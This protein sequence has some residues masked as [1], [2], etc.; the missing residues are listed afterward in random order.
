M[1]HF[2]PAISYKMTEKSYSYTKEKIT[3][4]LFL[5]SYYEILIYIKN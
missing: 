3:F 1:V 2:D 5:L 4:S